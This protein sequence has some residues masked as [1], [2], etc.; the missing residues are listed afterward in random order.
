VRIFKANKYLL[1]F[2]CPD[3]HEAF[4]TDRVITSIWVFPM[5]KKRGPK[6][7]R[8][9]F[10]LG[11]RLENSIAMEAYVLIVGKAF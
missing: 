1:V 3:G 4:E 2:T 7:H 10:L 6:S 5:G 9:H 8:M 11:G